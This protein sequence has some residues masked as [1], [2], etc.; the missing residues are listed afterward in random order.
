MG[1]LSKTCERIRGDFDHAMGELQK[2]NDIV[3]VLRNAFTGTGNTGIKNKGT[4]LGSVAQQGKSKSGY[5]LPSNAQEGLGSILSLGFG[6]TKIA[7]T[8]ALEADIALGC[9]YTRMAYSKEAMFTLEGIDLNL[10]NLLNIAR[11]DPDKAVA[12]AKQKFDVDK[13]VR[14]LDKMLNCMSSICDGSTDI[15]NRIDKLDKCV[16][17]IG[18]RSGGGIDVVKPKPTATIKPPA[19]PSM[20]VPRA[21]LGGW[22]GS[23]KK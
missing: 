16:T 10:N 23:F 1:V 20:P 13:K 19:K 8:M 15:Q 17:G 12:V 9:E 4:Q 22:G 18:L 11:I 3:N 14:K 2:A 6:D 21:P 5:S 7:A